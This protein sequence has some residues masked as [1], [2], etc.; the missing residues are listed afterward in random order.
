MFYNYLVPSGVPATA[1]ILAIQYWIDKYQL[2]KL[3][4]Q[5]YEMNY[6]LSRMILKIF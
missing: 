1:I 5:Y 3:S 4:S 6:F 2:F